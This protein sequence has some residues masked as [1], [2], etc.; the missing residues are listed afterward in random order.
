MNP[1]PHLAGL[2]EL[3]LATPCSVPWDLMQ[4]DEKKRFCTQ[5]GQNVYD[6]QNLTAA[7]VK[8]V[9]DKGEGK[10]CG[11]LFFRADG[12]LITKDCPTGLAAIAEK[13]SDEKKR[14]AL[15]YKSTTGIWAA[16]IASV[17]FA[18]LITFQ[19]RIKDALGIEA[20][21]EVRASPSEPRPGDPGAR[22]HP[23][24]NKTMGGFGQNNTY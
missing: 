17:L 13:F 24:I 21:R 7:E 4:G 2:G 6:V 15:H 5:C 22:N 23:L 11:M 14:A 16:A 9:L 1:A 20:R 12:R 18:L 3:K 10:A 8:E 19:D